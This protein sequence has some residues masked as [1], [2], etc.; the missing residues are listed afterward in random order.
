M[1][2]SSGRGVSTGQGEVPECPHCHKRHLGLCRLLTRGC[3]ICGSTEH[4][5]ANC[6]RELGIIG[7]CK[8]VA[9][10]DML[11]HLLLG[12]EEGVEVARFNREDVEV[13]CQRQWIVQCLQPQHEL[14]L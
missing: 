7:V 6:P 2:P 8:V 5:M 3:F 14:M 10:G 12:I 13:Q 11:H 4:W 1:V 9:E